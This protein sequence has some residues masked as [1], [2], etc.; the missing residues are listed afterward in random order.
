MTK[1]GR[2]IATSTPYIL[3]LIRARPQ[4]SKKFFSQGDI[5]GNFINFFIDFF[6]RVVI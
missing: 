2:L 6:N 4:F 5:G 3:C 1:G